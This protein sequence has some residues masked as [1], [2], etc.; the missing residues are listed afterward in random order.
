MEIEH[1]LPDTVSVPISPLLAGYFEQAFEQAQK[2]L[3]PNTYVLAFH[4]DRSVFMA[5]TS[6]IRYE[7]KK[8]IETPGWYRKKLHL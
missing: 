3:G 5:N 7:I 4:Y 1:R 6:Q 2:E 8:E